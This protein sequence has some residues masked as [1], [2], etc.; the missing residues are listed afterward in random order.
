MFGVHGRRKIKRRDNFPCFYCSK[1]YILSFIQYSM[2][3]LQHLKKLN[4]IELN[5]SKCIQITCSCIK[6]KICKVHRALV[7]K[8]N[9]TY[10]IIIYTFDACFRQYTCTLYAHSNILD[11]LKYIKPLDLNI[12]RDYWPCQIHVQWCKRRATSNAVHAT[13]VPSHVGCRRIM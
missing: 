13:C 6:F 11:T 10:I 9:D 8:L 5:C 7:I 2:F 3:Y 12:V 4:W 1:N